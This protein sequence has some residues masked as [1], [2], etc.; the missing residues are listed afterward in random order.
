MSIDRFPAATNLVDIK[1]HPQ[2]ISSPSLEQSYLRASDEVNRV[3]EN[4][5]TLND[6]GLLDGDD[7]SVA[8]AMDFLR[9]E[10]SNA[11]ASLEEAVSDYNKRWDRY[12][13]DRN[14]YEAML[15]E[16]ERPA[17]AAQ[18]V[19]D[20]RKGILS[21]IPE[22]AEQFAG[23]PS[24]ET[25][26]ELAREAHQALE[27]LESEYRDL[28]MPWV[29]PDPRLLPSREDSVNGA[30]QEVPTDE[31]E[32]LTM[33]PF[34][35]EHT[36]QCA[37]RSLDRFVRRK[38]CGDE[39]RQATS[40]FVQL[41]G[42]HVGKVFTTKEIASALYDTRPSRVDMTQ[43]EWQEVV[44][45]RVHALTSNARRDKI[46]KDAREYMEQNGLLLQWAEVR[47][48]GQRGYSSKVFRMVQIHDDTV[49]QAT[50]GDWTTVSRNL[51]Q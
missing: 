46:S 32:E 29:L 41:L 8:I 23:L 28:F 51:E 39:N 22:L 45:A 14:L 35:S 16:A 50:G 38:R 42:S 3:N 4:F 19:R 44:A 31:Y 34:T 6:K 27:G 37:A 2:E 17:Q 15:A 10:Q 30:T 49:G 20:Q 18:A 24:P 36:V 12:E 48:P 11:M 1:T 21:V 33:G 13:S 26:E 40:H 5:W 25:D 47:K 43:E 7:P 9:N